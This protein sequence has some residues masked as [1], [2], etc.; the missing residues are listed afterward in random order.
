MAMESPA[1]TQNFIG[2]Q[3]SGQTFL[4]FYQDEDRDAV[5]QAIA[6]C[7]TDPELIFDW[8]DAAMLI[9]DVALTGPSHRQRKT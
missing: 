5:L 1:R 8:T 9:R 3:K 6:K 2:L 7:A 4:F